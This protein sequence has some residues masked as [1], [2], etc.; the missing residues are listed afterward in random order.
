VEAFAAMSWRKIA[1]YYAAAIVLGGYLWFTHQARQPVEA[2]SGDEEAVAPI[3]PTLASRIDALVLRGRGM[4]VTLTRGE[5]SRWRIIQPSGLT[6]TSDL[7][8]ALLDTLTTI[9]PIEILSG[10]GE[11]LE[12][13]GLAPAEISLQ[14]RSGDEVAAELGLG[15]RNPTRTAVYAL[16]KGD[17]DVYLLGLNARY[18]LELVLD[19]LVRQSAGGGG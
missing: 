7:I 8:G 11:D 6:V 5:D 15:R 1:I 13:F 18:Y 14:L 3:V 2:G 16:K 9:S 4:E 10:H 12:S 19:E 17:A